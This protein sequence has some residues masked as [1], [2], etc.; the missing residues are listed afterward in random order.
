MR[1]FDQRKINYHNQKNLNINLDDFAFSFKDLSKEDVV[2]LDVLKS[3]LLSN[4][5]I[6]K[7][8][9]EEK[10]V[11]IIKDGSRVENSQLVSK[12]LKGRF[13]LSGL[14]FIES[15]FLN[16][17]IESEPYIREVLIGNKLLSNKEFINLT[18]RK[19]S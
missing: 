9:L 11:K 19:N 1:V 16:S 10:W 12:G 2:R 4:D 14:H 6:A 13:T 5:T 7:F 15:N 3:D 8:V 18:T 17:G